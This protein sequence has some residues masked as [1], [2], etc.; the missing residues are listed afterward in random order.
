MLLLF[1]FIIYMT[2]LEFTKGVFKNRSIKK[3]KLKKSD[4]LNSSS[5]HNFIKI[6]KEKYS[7]LFFCSRFCK[8][9]LWPCFAPQAKVL[10]PLERL[11]SFWLHLEGM[12]IWSTL[13]LGKCQNLHRNLNSE[14]SLPCSRH[15]ARMWS[16]I[17]SWVCISSLQSWPSRGDQKGQTA[18][19]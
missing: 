9:A 10:S 16:W 2:S 13:S 17:F 6:F 4:S 8:V 7:I 12:I 11:P 15:L 3:E 14:L 5:G 19:N 18:M 1:L